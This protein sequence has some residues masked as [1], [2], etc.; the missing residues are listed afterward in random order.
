MVLQQ[1]PRTCR[2]C[3]LGLRPS[4]DLLVLLGPLTHEVPLL[5]CPPSSVAFRLRGNFA[6]SFTGW[7]A[8]SL[9][10]LRSGYPPSHPF[11]L[12]F[13]KSEWWGV[14]TK[15]RSLRKLRGSG[16]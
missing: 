10:V 3:S 8:G 14:E 15:F 4:F 12:K 16:H 1:D 9:A 11:P 7:Q 6:L 5:P 2:I 13:I